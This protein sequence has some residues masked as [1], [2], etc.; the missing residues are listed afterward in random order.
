MSVAYA[1]SDGN[2]QRASVSPLPSVVKSYISSPVVGNPVSALDKRPLFDADYFT[3]KAGFNS[4][5]NWQPTRYYT[6]VER[7]NLY[8]KLNSRVKFR[9]ILYENPFPRFKISTA[10]QFETRGFPNRH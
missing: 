2:T 8:P 9:R 5:Y 3:S 4:D 10:N 6:A 7:K 1:T